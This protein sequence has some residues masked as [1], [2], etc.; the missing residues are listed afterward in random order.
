MGFGSDGSD[1]SDNDFS[2]NEGRNSFEHA[3]VST[4]SALKVLFRR[5]DTSQ[6]GTI[7]T[8]EL[9]DM[10]AEMYRL[11]CDL[12]NTQIQQHIAYANQD[13]SKSK[14]TQEQC[15]CNYHCAL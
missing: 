8:N 14:A 3:L 5:Y 13:V 15:S 6:D 12:D 2:D 4:E 7:D 1:G 10:M 9:Q 11:H